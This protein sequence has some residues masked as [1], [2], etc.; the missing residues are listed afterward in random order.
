MDW[1]EIIE[2]RSY[3]FKPE[4]LKELKQTIVENEQDE[5]LKAFGIY[6][7]ASVET[8]TGIHIHWKTREDRIKRS[9]LGLRIALAL[10][11]FGPVN[12]AIWIED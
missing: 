11:E 12:H 5:G 8:D 4:T 3:R 6:H 10:K 9:S 1:I 7:N 2:L